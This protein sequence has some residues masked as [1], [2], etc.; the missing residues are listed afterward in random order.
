M[1]TSQ[2]R[3]T[4]SRT[5]VLAAAI[6]QADAGGLDALNMR[7]LAQEL[8]VVPM[9]LY[10]HVANKEDLLDGMIEVVVGEIEPTQQTGE[11]KPD[12][13]ARILA[14][15]AG[16]RRHSWSRAVLESREAMTPA[17]LDYLNALTGLF[18]DGGLS[19]DLTHHV[20]HALGNRMWG[21]SQELFAATPPSDPSF[22]THKDAL[23]T[24]FPHLAAIARAAAHG[25]PGS[26]TGLGCD[27][28]SEFEFALDLLL[29]GVE[30]L[31]SRQWSSRQPA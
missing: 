21:F 7:N 10:K 5:R 9:A 17:M 4:L 31:H 16:L 2:R 6:A 24:H 13:R 15:R 1:S 18:L 12:V 20:M 19:A 11:W 29:D 27:D 14:A 28:K 23:P 3:E 8:G 22:T 25:D 26:A 30:V